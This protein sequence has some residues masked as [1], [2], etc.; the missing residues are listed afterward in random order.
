MAPI[1]K[2]IPTV[3]VHAPGFGIAALLKHLPVTVRSD[4]FLFSDTSTANLI[5]LPPNALV[6]NV[7]INVTTAFDASGTSAAATATLSIPQDSGALTVWDAAN[8]ALQSTGMVPASTM[9]AAI[10][11]AASGG[12]AILT[13]TANTTTAGALEVYLS[14]IPDVTKLV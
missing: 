9:P 5:E 14:Y 12:Y 11:A 13:Y 6:T 4:A 2:P 3:P 8:L 7:Q 1:V 10:P